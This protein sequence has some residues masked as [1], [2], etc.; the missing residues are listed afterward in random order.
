[1]SDVKE[2]KD[3]NTSRA[4]S[5][6]AL[7]GD[8]MALGCGGNLT[9]AS[10]G[11]GAMLWEAEPALP[12]DELEVFDLRGQLTCSAKNEAAIPSIFQLPKDTLSHA[13]DS[14][15]QVSSSG[16]GGSNVKNPPVSVH[17]DASKIDLS[18][19][20]KPE[21]APSCTDS[22]G[23]ICIVSGASGVLRSIP[24]PLLS[25]D[26]LAYDN[27]VGTL[28]VAGNTNRIMVAIPNVDNGDSWALP[29]MLDKS[30]GHVKGISFQE[31]EG[32]PPSVNLLLAV[33]Q[34]QKEKETAVI[35]SAGATEC[36]LQIHGFE[37]DW[38]TCIKATALRP[39]SGSPISEGLGGL[40]LPQVA[41]GG[42]C[43]KIEE[44]V[45]GLPSLNGGLGAE[46][47]RLG[48]SEEAAIGRLLSMESGLKVLSSSVSKASAH[49]KAERSCA[50]PIQK[51]TAVIQG[52]SSEERT[53]S[54]IGRLENSM[55]RMEEKLDRLMAHLGC[56]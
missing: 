13:L 22:S 11:P 2:W 23:C 36:D 6:I 9:L 17:A 26:V 38:P 43:R 50:P 32:K 52:G 14:D 28:L 48:S 39:A 51:P 34:V 45:I 47:I 24:V 4:R 46:A 15:M 29:I 5:V 54:R 55:E 12:K 53:E 8:Q 19:A 25:P 37:V 40:E 41:G 1:M 30:F 21:E 35:F 49:V 7:V 18:N 27:S 3:A 42:A 33:P 10:P 31:K 20:V 44:M 56:R 16:G